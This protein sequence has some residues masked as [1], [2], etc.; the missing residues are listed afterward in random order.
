MLPPPARIGRK[1]SSVGKSCLICRGWVHRRRPMCDWR[2]AHAALGEFAAAESLLLKGA[3]Q[4]PEDLTLARKL[5]DAATARKDWPE[6]VK[7]WQ[8][9]L[10]LQG[11]DAPATTYVR[12]AQAHAALRE[13][14]TAESLLLKGAAQHP[15]DLTLAR[16][17]ADAATARKDWPE[18]VKR[19]QK[20]LDLQG[21]GAPATTYVRLAE[22]HA[23]VGDLAAAELLLLRGSNQHP[24]DLTLARM[25][26][27]IASGRKDWAE[28]LKR[29]QSVLRL[30]G[31]TEA[32]IGM[33][34]AYRGRGRTLEGQEVLRRGLATDPKN[35]RILIE[36]ALSYNLTASRDR[37][38]LSREADRSPP[39][40]EIVIC[41]RN[42]LEATRRC[43]ESVLSRTTSPFAL[44]L[45]DD[46]SDAAMRD[47]LDSLVIE[48]S[49][50]RL[51]R[52]SENIG[53]TRSANLGLKAARADW[54]VLLNSDTVLTTDWLEGLL[55]CALSRQVIKAVGPL[56][57]AATF[58]SVPSMRGENGN[59]IINELPDHVSIEQMAKLIRSVS[60]KSF[61]LVPVLNGF[62]MLLSKAAL[63][64]VGYLDE[65]HFPRG[66]GEENDLCLRLLQAGH[67]L[68]I[69]DHVYV[70]HLKSA[71]FGHEERER[72]SREATAQ[73]KK[74]WPE[75]G[76]SY[77]AQEL[78][79]LPTM[80]Q[81][82]AN[83]RQA[84]NAIA[85]ETKPKP[86]A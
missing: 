49:W 66:Y 79:E 8:K 1:R 10:D 69:A 78:E 38:A 52:N 31:D 54:V 12:L 64:Q 9:L 77:V 32:A 81:T 36:L 37:I 44:T 74:L 35:A 68:A 19:W 39:P 27:E 45:I 80:A 67:G 70:H 29:W 3:A 82:R 51:I 15:E 83:I 48:H 71:S 30:G 22:A 72:L 65:D 23:A 4:H 47:Y 28:A 2:E 20:L 26:A 16:K 41:I 11:L 62:C 13:F 85:A 7:R 50:L 42:A 18:A 53:Y 63:D 86:S 25:F 14:A 58:Q 60:S 57:N 76:Y 33:Y 61:P 5:A 34:R 40:T 75:F 73:M 43:I 56:S 55:E 84:L 17:L 59:F 6:A 21:L 46:C 24:E